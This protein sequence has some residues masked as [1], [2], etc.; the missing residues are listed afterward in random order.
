MFKYILTAFILISCGPQNK[1]DNQHPKC[2]CKCVCPKCEIVDGKHNCDE[3]GCVCECPK[4]E[5]KEQN[6]GHD[7]GGGGC[8]DG[9]CGRPVCQ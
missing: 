7:R 6:E 3:C 1:S 4:K 8:D 5:G 9:S 2:P